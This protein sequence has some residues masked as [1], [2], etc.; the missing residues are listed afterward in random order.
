MYKKYVLKEFPNA[1]FPE[2][3]SCFDLKEYKYSDLE[4]KENQALIRVVWISS[5]PLLRT[6]ISGAK[7]YLDPVKPGSPIPGFGLGRVIKVNKGNGKKIRHEKN[8]WVV[9]M[10]EW[11]QFMVADI[12]I[13]QRLPVDVTPNL[14]SWALACINS[15]RFTALQDLPHSGPSNVKSNLLS[16]WTKTGNQ[17][18]KKISI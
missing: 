15:S 13:I 14:F 3:L 16:F 8:D 2:D 9:G 1:N 10:L 18:P 11:S 6:W 4:P 12:S 5:D 17:K 7:S